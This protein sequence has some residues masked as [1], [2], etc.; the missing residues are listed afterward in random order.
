MKIKGEILG[1]ALA[2][3]VAALIELYSYNVNVSADTQIYNTDSF[4]NFSE[5]NGTK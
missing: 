1:W 2:L 4:Q 5:K 3:G